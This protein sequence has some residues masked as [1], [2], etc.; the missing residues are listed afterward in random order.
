MQITDA[1]SSGHTPVSGPHERRDTAPTADGPAR[2]DRGFE[3]S[4]VISLFG[5]A[6]GAGVLFLPINAGLGGVWPL[7]IA[8]V[9]IGPMTYFSHR[10]LSRFVCADPKP[11]EDITA[12]ARRAFGPGAG[13]AITILY[14][15]AVY[16]IVLI[17][18]V[19]I[20]NTVESLLVNQL[21]IPAPPRALL[22]FVLIGLMMAVM[23]T[24]QKLMLR[25]TSLLVYPLIAILFAMSVYLIPS[26]DVGA[27]FGSQTPELGQILMSVWLVIPV[28]VFAFNHSPAIS[29]FSL[30]MKR[31]YAGQ[32]ATRASHVLVRTTALLVVFTMFF[33]WSCVLA[34][35]ADGMAEAKAANLPVLSYLANVHDAP[36]IALLGPIVAI[37]AIIS[38]FFGHYL[39]AA[40]GAAGIVRSL[41]D[42]DGSKI[43]DKALNAAIAAFIFLTTWVVAIVNPQVLTLIETIAGPII[44][45]ILYLMPMYAMHRLEALAPYRRQASNVFVVI[46]GLVAVSGIVYGVVQTLTGA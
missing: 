1:H 38:S 10:A 20:T 6:V 29:Q 11:G 25:I 9:L 12:V 19:S 27:L 43:S 21:E 36:V 5:T 3:R 13:A 23:L 40:E 41:V 7:L 44:A 45:V 34:L 30:A 22:S 46:A 15:F 17:Y 32:A 14:F 18:G 31:H 2:P 4:W 8:T 39:G 26:W 24:G 35:G 42:R 33:V 16:P 28:L 37:L